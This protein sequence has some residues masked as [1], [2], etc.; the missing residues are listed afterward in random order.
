MRSDLNLNE[1]TRSELVQNLN[2]I[3][4]CAAT[5]DLNAKLDTAIRVNV[6]GPLQL[7]ELA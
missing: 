5:V 2:I 3:I 7:L 1:K 6:T 4:N